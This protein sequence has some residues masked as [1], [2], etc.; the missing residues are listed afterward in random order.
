MKTTKRN[1]FL[2]LFAVLALSV[3]QAQDK[4]VEFG[5]SAG[6]GYTM[7]RVK[8]ENNINS[9]INT[10]NLSGFHVG[11]HLKLNVDEQFSFQTGLLFNYFS[12]VT[13]D[14]YQQYLKKAEGTWKQNRTKLMA[15]D[16]PFRATYSAALAE[17]FYFF[18]FAGPNLNYSVNKVVTLE[19]YSNRKLL[20][21]TSSE[22]IYQK[23]SNYNAFDLQLGAGLGVQW[24]G[25]SIR[26]SYDWGVLNRTIIEKTALRSNDLK[27][28]L[29]YTF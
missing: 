10:D 18:V 20:S 19:N 22:N 13:I 1:I 2:V 17:D 27:V 24:M 25:V 29:G 9:D 23:P 5:F 6:Y 21:S 3:M 4:K 26:G 16:L 15:F 11:P 28:T 7:P 12:T 8:T 14:R